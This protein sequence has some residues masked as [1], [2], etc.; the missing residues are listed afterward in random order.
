M[1]KIILPLMLLFMAVTASAQSYAKQPDPVVTNVVTYQKPA[2]E[3]KE[4]AVEN[5]KRQEA[6]EAVPNE[7]K[8]GYATT[9]QVAAGKKERIAENEARPDGAE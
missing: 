3:S 6:K 7:K 8:P 2:Q 4:P 5:E 1:K 9:P